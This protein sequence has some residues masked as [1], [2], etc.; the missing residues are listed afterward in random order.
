[1]AFVGYNPLSTGYRL[2]DARRKVVCVS[3]DVTFDEQ[4]P[5]STVDSPLI[6]GDSVDPPEPCTAPPTSDPSSST[7]MPPPSSPV[8]S[9]LS[10]P[11][12]PMDPGSTA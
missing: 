10:F 8:P 6:L 5:S 4:V 12:H 2:Y 3:R 9:L 1:M 11:A 7:L